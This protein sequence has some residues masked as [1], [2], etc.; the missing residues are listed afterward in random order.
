MVMIMVDHH[1]Q[2]IMGKTTILHYLMV[3]MDSMEEEVEEE[4]E[5]TLLNKRIMVEDNMGINGIIMIIE[6]EEG[7]MVV[8][9]MIGD[10][11]KR[12]VYKILKDISFKSSNIDINMPLN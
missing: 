3:V 1:H 12:K 5:D 11:N 6:V 2:I 4:E 9:R 7:F 8:I 10:N